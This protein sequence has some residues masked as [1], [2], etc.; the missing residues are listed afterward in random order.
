MPPILGGDS[1]DKLVTSQSDH[2]NRTEVGK[3]SF[4]IVTELSGPEI[5]LMGG[6]QPFSV[7]G[8]SL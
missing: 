2:N 4:P 7:T 5:I 3:T 8:V 6:L 1:F